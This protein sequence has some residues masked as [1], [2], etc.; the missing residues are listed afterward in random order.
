MGAS[1]GDE[2][3]DHTEE[4]IAR[5][6]S[7]GG[8]AEEH[9]PEKPPPPGRK[10]QARPVVCSNVDAVKSA[11]SRMEYPLSFRIKGG[12]DR[13]GKAQLDLVRTI[14]AEVEVGGVAEAMFRNHRLL[15]MLRQRRL[16]YNLERE[17]ALLQAKV[18][19]V[20][21]EKDS[22][23][24]ARR[25]GQGLVE[26]LASVTRD[27]S[28]AHSHLSTGG[29]SPEIIVA[30]ARGVKVGIQHE[31]HPLWDPTLQ[32]D[33]GALMA[34]D[35]RMMVLRA[36]YRGDANAIHKVGVAEEMEEEYQE[37]LA[38]PAVLQEKLESQRKQL[39]TFL[40]N[41]GSAE[42]IAET[43][44]NV[45]MLEWDMVQAK[46]GAIRWN[47]EMAKRA[48]RIENLANAGGRSTAMS[49]KSS[50]DPAPEPPPYLAPKESFA[51]PGAGVNANAGTTTEGMRRVAALKEERMAVDASD[52]AAHPCRAAPTEHQVNQSNNLHARWVALSLAA[53]EDVPDVVHHLIDMGARVATEK[54]I[55]HAHDSRAHL[56]ELQVQ[57][58]EM[59]RDLADSKHVEIDEVAR[60]IDA[61]EEE[62]MLVRKALH[63]LPPTGSQREKIRLNQES[64]TANRSL[65]TLRLKR[66]ELRNEMEEMEAK[67]RA[68]DSDIPASRAHLE[69]LEGALGDH[70]R[71]TALHRACQLHRPA[72][73]TALI[74]AGHMPDPEDASGNSP[75]HFAAAHANAAC[76]DALADAL[77]ARDAEQ[78][79][80][81]LE[82]QN[83]FGQRPIDL[84]SEPLTRLAFARAIRRL[85]LE[86]TSI[87][88]HIA[89]RTRKAPAAPQDGM[90]TEEDTPPFPGETL[91]DRVVG[92][93]QDG[94]EDPWLPSL[95]NPPLAAMPWAVPT[96]W[97]AV[98]EFDDAM[99]A[100]HTKPSTDA[101][102]PSPPASPATRGQSP[103]NVASHPV[104]VSSRK[105]SLEPAPEADVH[106]VTD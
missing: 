88:Y 63:E 21:R 11:A 98:A 7:P 9:P 84:V 73:V 77:I 70:A 4:E 62:V 22:A 29:P 101:V 47:E 81:A 42:R 18:K 50:G 27:I 91:G 68:L 12:I 45:R 10:P 26:E 102:P 67:L 23:F 72:M 58:E 97:W 93:R 28:T 34:C 33:G 90:E 106:R 2:Q 3:D 87:H 15:E 75:L 74:A 24:G 41:D 36:A 13:R 94:A 35:A 37:A 71:S 59:G 86:A 48:D 100:L 39:E 55:S 80:S 65:R 20:E 46:T 19:E 30:E 31:G 85:G 54:L 78:L 82:K 96:T 53:A 1:E 89:P 25:E 49:A 103:G 5:R 51:P 79:R 14:W 92:W 105:K 61:L 66:V 17:A 99:Q 40:A 104:G 43:T 57:R 38:L 52:A 64:A 60:N 44:E 76:V 83:A 95:L 16:K 6:T 56:R 8:E 32:Q 69:T